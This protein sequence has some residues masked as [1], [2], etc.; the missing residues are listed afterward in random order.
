MTR[1]WSKG[2]WRFI[3]LKDLNPSGRSGSYAIMPGGWSGKAEDVIEEYDTWYDD[4]TI[5]NDAPYYNE[6]PSY[7]D[8]KLIALTPRMA[9]A[10]LA[11][12]EHECLT[13]C[14]ECVWCVQQEL[15][16]MI[17]EAEGDE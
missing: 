1:P 12:S 9:E 6:A 17:D 11:S 7:N 14:G 16:A 3:P 15:R 5:C 2:P 4:D 8:A 13:K 10:I